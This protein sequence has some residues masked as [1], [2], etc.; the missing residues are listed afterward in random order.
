MFENNY[1]CLNIGN[2]TRLQIVG[3]VA[4]RYSPDISFVSVDLAVKF[5][6]IVTNESLNSDHL[7]IKMKYKFQN[8][9]I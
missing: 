6:L 4:Q 3:N 2:C 5:T 8:E 1:V 9:L 7:I